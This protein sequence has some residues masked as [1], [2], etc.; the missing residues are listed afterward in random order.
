MGILGIRFG[1]VVAKI[2]L[3]LKLVR[4]T[5][6]TCHLVGKYTRVCKFR[7]I[8]IKTPLILLISAFFV[9][10]STFTQSNNMRAVLE[11][12]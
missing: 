4:I 8:S 1:V 11:I 7:K 9:K 5:L 10:N 6:E 3:C 12:F 2:T